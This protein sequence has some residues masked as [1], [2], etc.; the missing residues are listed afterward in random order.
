MGVNTRLEE[1]HNILF[2]RESQT[3]VL[4]HC[5]S[6]EIEF[7]FIPPRA[8]HFGGLCK[9]PVKSAKT[10]INRALPSTRLSFEEITKVLIAIEA[11]LN[12]RPMSPL[13]DDPNDL[14]PLTPRHF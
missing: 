13:T 8:P 5:S 11:S 2:K 3:T 6:E 10:V 12:S 7:S 4:K 1:F 14:R 9:D